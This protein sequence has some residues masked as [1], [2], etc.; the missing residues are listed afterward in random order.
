MPRR[1]II[2]I[3]CARYADSWYTAANG[4]AISYLR[5]IEAAGGVPALIHHTENSD[6]LA[7]QYQRCDGFIFAGGTDIDPV[8]YAAERHPLLEQ[9]DPQQDSLELALARRA[10]AEGKP[11][12]GICRGIQLLNVAMGG[13]LHQDIPSVLPGSMHH[14]ESTERRDM[15]YLAHTITIEETAWLA[16][17]LGTSELL[18]NTLHHQALATIA[19]GLRVVACAPDGVVEAVES[20]GSGFILGVQCHPEEL[21]DRADTRWARVFAR[22]VAAIA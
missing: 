6:V 3:P 9:P 16:E 11:V 1:P 13:T 20:S 19:P 21:W 14:A 5:A 15:A 22:F 12:F 17:S 10:I 4:N 8:C 2:G 18:V 7:I